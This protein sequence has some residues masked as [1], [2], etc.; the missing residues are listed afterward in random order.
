VSSGIRV[1]VNPRRGGH[2]PGAGAASVRP[3]PARATVD[4]V[5]TFH[6]RLPGYAPTP[7]VELGDLARELGIGRLLVKVEAERLGLPSFKILGASW[8]TYRA[9][10]A[11]L[12]PFGAWDSLDDLRR[13][14]ARSG[15][16]LVAATDG[17]HGRAV[18]RMARLLGLGAR[19][20]VPTGTAQPRMDGITS[21][22][23]TLEVVEGT[24][25]DAVARSARLAADDPARLLISDTSWPGYET[26]PAWVID[27]YATIF[28][29]V[30]EVL[31]R[32]PIDVAVIPVGVGALAAAAIRHLR[33]PTRAR[34][35]RVVSVEAHDAACVLESIVAGR[36]VTV[37]GPH[38]S[39]MAGL[40][41]G[42]PSLIALPDLLDGIAVATAV[43][44][45]LDLRAMADL[46]AAGVVAGECGAATLAGLRLALLDP[47]ARAA[48]EA[49]P[50]STVLLLSTEGITDPASYARAMALR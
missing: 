50:A 30:D 4:E 23:A 19:I 33:A 8:A 37:P 28:A 36:M 3:T 29:E 5:R 31:G 6:R 9:L 38:R 10:D 13:V 34:L 43:N 39:I 17:N 26:I 45:D 40:N 41:A 20:L 16:E 12:G 25:D 14:V 48:L 2:H 22:G 42:E 1:A 21:E 24:Y 15:I 49:G 46:A 27:G 47:A 32:A 7:L 35:A 11:R 18:A 44:D